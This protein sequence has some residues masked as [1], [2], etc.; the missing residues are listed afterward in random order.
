MFIEE[1]I[2]KKTIG[3]YKKMKEGE[4]KSIYFFLKREGVTGDLG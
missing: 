2:D 3:K 1:E 4:L